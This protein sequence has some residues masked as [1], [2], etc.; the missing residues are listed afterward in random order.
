MLILHE[1][2]IHAEQSGPAA[3]RRFSVQK[4]GITENGDAL[5]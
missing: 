3:G 1:A 5:L 4:K 2:Q